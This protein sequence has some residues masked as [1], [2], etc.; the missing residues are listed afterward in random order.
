MFKAL[1]PQ[2][3]TPIGVKDYIHLLRSY[4]TIGDARCPACNQPLA[5]KGV[6]SPNP[7]VKPHFAHRLDDNAP[8]CPIKSE[9][10]IR[11]EV[12]TECLPDTDAAQALR[13]AFFQNWAYH[14]HQFRR[15]VKTVD[16]KDF[17]AALKEVDQRRVW[18]YKDIREHEIII[19]ML[20]TRDF[21]PVK[22]QDG[23]VW[24]SKWVRFWFKSEVRSLDDFWNLGDAQKILVR[25][26]YKLSER[27][28]KIRENA[29][30][31][32]DVVPVESSYMSEAADASVPEPVR[33]YMVKSFPKLIA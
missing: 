12:L 6:E 32:F 7:S 14:W 21:K 23:K 15:Y 9:G 30:K 24:R 10:A 31:D 26:E 25:A 18:R 1:H 13:K 29:F 19:A 17:A 22:A 20:A 5:L 2:H 27:A 8:R 3:D 16:V 33:R 11:Y 28:T 4:P